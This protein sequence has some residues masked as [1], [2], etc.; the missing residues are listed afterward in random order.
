MLICRETCSPPARD[1]G[2]SPEMEISGGTN[3]CGGGSQT[4]TQTGASRQW[5]RSQGWV[6]LFKSPQG[7]SQKRQVL[8][9]CISLQSS[10]RNFG[11]L[12]RFCIPRQ[13]CFPRSKGRKARTPS[14]RVVNAGADARVMSR[15]LSDR[16]VEWAPCAWR[17]VRRM[18]GRQVMRLVSVHGPPNGRL[19]LG[20]EPP[21][22]IWQLAP[23]R[24]RARRTRLELGGS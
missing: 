23:H 10:F 2:S 18:R 24:P 11:V 15:Q 3:R 21:R 5:P 6:S 1:P 22:R 9:R 17:V 16:A 4:Q 7:R 14:S 19:H 8:P 12:R 13:V 20:H